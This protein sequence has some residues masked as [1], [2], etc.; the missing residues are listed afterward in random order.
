MRHQPVPEPRLLDVHDVAR[1]YS[2]S[3]RSVWRLCKLGQIPAPIQF[4]QR[5]TRWRVSDLTEHIGK[6]KPSM[7]RSPATFVRTT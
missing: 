7:P 1:L 5:A 4:G 6:L 3:E 2:I